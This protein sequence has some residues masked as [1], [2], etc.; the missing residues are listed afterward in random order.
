MSLQLPL[1]PDPDSTDNP[2][3][4]FQGISGLVYYRDFLTPLQQQL[5]LDDI[6]LQPWRDD[7][8][9]R[10][11]HY[12]YRYDYK[13]RRV[14]TS[15]YLGVLPP[16]LQVLATRLVQLRLMPEVPDQ[17]IVNE[18]LPG[19]G[20]S[21][22]VDCEPCFGPSIATISVGAVYAMDF[23]DTLSKD[24]RV[25][26]L[27]LGSCLVFS[28]EARYRWKHGIK[29]RLSDDGAPRSRRVS[30]TFRKVTLKDPVITA[31]A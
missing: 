6:E 28:G 27:E 17:A 2:E 13:A 31:F 5:L 26:K 23:T 29:P 10:V 19:Q 9:R 8:K 14:D 20:I 25:F 4:N 7:L 24:S 16:F 30:I 1:F 21:P 22:H 18:Y 15:M 3:F 11:Q 12:G